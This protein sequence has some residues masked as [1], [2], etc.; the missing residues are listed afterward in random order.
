M[1]PDLPW[2]GVVFGMFISNV[3]YW[4]T[5]QVRIW[6]TSVFNSEE[7]GSMALATRWR[8]LAGIIFD[9]S[10]SAGSDGGISKSHQLHRFSAFWLRS[11]CSICSYQLNI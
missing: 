7:Y 5:D 9:G 8:T 11:K 2:A 1:E 10:I 4:C 3:W 6:G